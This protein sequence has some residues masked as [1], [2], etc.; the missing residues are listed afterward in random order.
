MW[1]FNA[2]DAQRKEKN[3]PNWHGPYTIIE[4]LEGG[5]YKLKDRYS[6]KLA[7]AVPQVQLC[8]DKPKPTEVVQTAKYDAKSAERESSSTQPTT[9]SS[10]QQSTQN[11]PQFE[12]FTQEN[13]D[14]DAPSQ[15]PPPKEDLVS[16]ADESLDAEAEAK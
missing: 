16:D 10:S 11:P 12:E 2:K 5:L 9:Q 8:V 6:H 15:P 7:R 3:K 1:K 13:A 14:Y 4:V